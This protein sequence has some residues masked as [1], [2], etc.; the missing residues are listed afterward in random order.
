MKTELI[1]FLIF[2]LTFGGTAI[3]CRT[4]DFIEKQIENRRRERL[5]IKRLEK[6]NERLKKTNDFLRLQYEISERKISASP[7]RYP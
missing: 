1:T 6:E 5:N 2:C 4:V 3:I 7:M